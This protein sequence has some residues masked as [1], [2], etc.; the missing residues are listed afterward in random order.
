MKNV[1]VSVLDLK[2]EFFGKPF[3]A[4]T[5]G[6]AIRIFTDGINDNQTT[7][8]QHPEDFALYHLADYDDQTG[9]VTRIEPPLLLLAGT[10]VEKR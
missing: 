4:R 10:S 7:L 5:P 8:H 1:L 9:I 2:A 6:E 3:A